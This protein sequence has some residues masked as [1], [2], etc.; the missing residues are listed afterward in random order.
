MPSASD[1]LP[2]VY[3]QAWIALG[4]IL[5][6]YILMTVVLH[7]RPQRRVTVARYE[8]PHGI[9]PAIAAYLVESGRCERAFAAALVSLAAKGFLTIQQDKELF[10]L[11]K[12]R[13]P[14]ASLPAEEF[15]ALAALLPGSLHTRTFDAIDCSAVLQAYAEFEEAIKSVANPQL[16]SPHLGVWVSG[17]GSSLAIILFVITSLPL[18]ENS[19]SLASLPYVGMFILFGGICFVA[20]MHVWPST[21][22]KLTSF[23]PGDAR[24][25][26][27]LDAN[28]AVP[29]ILTAA[30]FVGFGFL[31]SMTSTRFALLLTAVVF[32]STLFRHL[33][34]APTRAGRKVLAEL[35]DFREFLA[36]V[37]ADRLTRLNQSGR[38]PQ[39]LESFSGYAIALDVEHSW[40]E[41][42]SNTLLELLEIERAYH[43]RYPNSLDAGGGR[44]DLK[45]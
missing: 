11:Q 39:T 14:D 41:D 43:P 25:S 10:T 45:L 4:L 24:P 17:L 13:E 3:I 15:A 28:D 5:A 37:H 30:A 34:Q 22:R 32:L 27:P 42:F 29:L 19:P 7:W 31:A 21:I 6:Y 40:G 44:I 1:A 2:L 26:R 20:A 33:L 36:R 23:F 9:S 16:L 18:F 38:T 35:A 12:R 8:A